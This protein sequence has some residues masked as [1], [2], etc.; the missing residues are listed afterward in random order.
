MEDIK[1][2]GYR[3]HIAI[4]VP[5]FYENILKYSYQFSIYNKNG[6][7]Q[8]YPFSRIV[9]KT[10][11]EFKSTLKENFKSYLNYGVIE[12]YPISKLIK[13]LSENLA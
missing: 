9:A 13:T 3:I 5:Q 6:E 1:I 4:K 11:A 8:N 12:A 10:D 7:I 2:K